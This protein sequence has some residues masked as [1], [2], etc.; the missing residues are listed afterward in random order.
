MSKLRDQ[1]EKAVGLCWRMQMLP[2]P[3]FICQPTVYNDEWHDTHRKSWS[4]EPNQEL[5]YYRPVLMNSAGGTVASRGLVGKRRK[6]CG[7]DTST[8]ITLPQD[9]KS[10]LLSV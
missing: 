5:V 1:V 2:T 6:Q 9:P 7:M 4:D 10:K 3:M 8:V